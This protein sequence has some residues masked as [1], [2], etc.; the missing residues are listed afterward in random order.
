[1]SEK[2]AK[3]ED[4]VEFQE[5]KME[6]PANE[7][8]EAK[9]KPEIYEPP[10]FPK[11]NLPEYQYDSNKIIDGIRPEATAEGAAYERELENARLEMEA[12]AVVKPPPELLPKAPPPPPK[13]DDYFVKPLETPAP[14]PEPKPKMPEPTPSPETLI[15]TKYVEYIPPYISNTWDR[16]LVE[17]FEGGIPPFTPKPVQREEERGWTLFNHRSGTKIKLVF[18]IIICILAIGLVLVM[19]WLIKELYFDKRK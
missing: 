3:Q 18:V 17:T 11:Q 9:P 16:Y 1:M 5:P 8:M 13:L 19:L 12:R 7:S 10:V 14:A 6:S 15:P 4:K 2:Q